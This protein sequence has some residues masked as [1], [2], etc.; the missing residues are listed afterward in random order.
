MSKTKN[1]ITIFSRLLVLWLFV[2]IWWGISLFA[3]LEPHNQIL[4]TD[5]IFLV[6]GLL[7]FAIEFFIIDIKAFVC[8]IAV[9]L[10]MGIL[11]GI[12]LVVELEY[13]ILC[14]GK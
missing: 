11:L 13:S 3:P 14:K 9:I 2:A 8:L 1:Y 7:L 6:M 5:L 10:L 4:K 12:W